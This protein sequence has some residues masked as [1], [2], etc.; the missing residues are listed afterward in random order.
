[1]IRGVC[2]DMDGLLFDTE[3][4]GADMMYK[5]VEEQG[6]K[7]TEAQWRANLGQNAA[8]TKQA[9]R[10]WFGNS[11]DPDRFFTDWCRLMVEHIR[12]S[13]VPEKAG[14][15]AALTALREHGIRT[16]L[17]TSN[18]EDVV[19]EYLAL[20]GFRPFFDVI[21]TG[22]M[23]QHG[24]PA[25]DIYLKA[26]EALGLSPAECAGV[27]DSLNG[28]KAIR[29]AGMRCVMV[30]DT[31][32]Y[33]PDFAPHVDDCLTTLNEL[34]DTLFAKEKMTMRT[35]LD[36]FLDYVQVETTSC[37]TNACC[38]STPGQMELAKLLVKELR[39]M[40]VA[41][42]RVDE[43][44]YVYASIPAKGDHPARVGFIAHMDTSDA[45]KGPVHPQVIKNYDGKPI[46][47]KNGMVIDGFDFLPG[48]KGQDLVVTDGTSVLGGDDKAGVAEIMTLAARLMAPDAPEHCTVCIGFTPDEEIGRGA[49]LFNVADFHA[50]YAYTVDGG[51]VG[52]M[53]YE[54][55]NAAAA[56]VEVRGV[57]IHPGSAKNQMKNAALIAMEFNGMLP[58]WETPSHTEGYEGFYHLCEMQ[59]DEELATLSYILRDHDGAKLEQK[60]TTLLQIAAYLNQKWGE[61]TVK[62]TIKDSYRNMKEM[63]LPHMEI[64]DKAHAAFEACGV[65]FSVAPIRGG[66]DGARLSYMGLLCPNLSTGGYNCHGRKE[67][68]SVQGMETMVDVLTEIVKRA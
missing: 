32:P 55:F 28:V 62:V 27:E 67:L 44:G 46:T 53:E 39:D 29:A 38:P 40:G 31:Q 65:K 24:K 35:V 41:D 64:I 25:P 60:K 17:V 6:C 47:L 20:S 4:L 33:G 48:L 7:L 3:W 45:V 30:P 9:L 42:A 34:Y 49:D 11:I 18:D 2:F 12:E 19:A 1:M 5:A 26:A 14:A 43:N 16:A 57:N 15:R 51:A 23:V 36:R 59:G 63:L 8:A 54:N 58:P 21:V 22:G 13:G 10:N 66:T 68:V 61:G 56:V 50:D 37:E 52:E